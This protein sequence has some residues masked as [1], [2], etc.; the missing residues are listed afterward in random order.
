MELVSDQTTEAG[1][2]TSVQSAGGEERRFRMTEAVAVRTA[3][4]SGSRPSSAAEG[5][6]R[7]QSPRPR[8]QKAC[9]RFERKEWP[10]TDLRLKLL[11]QRG[12]QRTRYADDYDVEIWFHVTGRVFSRHRTTASKITLKKTCWLCNMVA[13]LFPKIAPSSWN[14]VH[15]V[16]RDVIKIYKNISI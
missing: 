2:L 4:L 1:I 13:I 8:S 16:Q 14:I 5:V 9:V 15:V 7:A 6:R 11:P 3:V 10:Q 12:T